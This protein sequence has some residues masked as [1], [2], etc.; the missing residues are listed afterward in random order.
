MKKNI[1]GILFIFL[2]L[3]SCVGEAS[4]TTT[5]FLTSDNIIGENEDIDMLNSIKNYVEE[6]SNG[7]IKV[8]VDSQAPS[9]GEGSRAIE[10]G[11]DVSVNLAASDAGNFLILAKYA[12]NSGKKIIFVNTGDFD[13]DSANSLRRAWDDDYSSTIFAGIN[14][15]GTYLKEAGIDYIQPLQVYPDAGPKGYLSE[16]NE[17]VNKYIAE[18]IVESVS[19]NNSHNYNNDLVITHKLAPKEMAKASQSLVESDDKQMNGT[20][21][22]YT[23]P[24]VLYLTSSYLNG[25]GLQSPANY[26]PPTDPEQYSTFAKGSYSIYDYM[27]M[28]G[29][30]K[31]FMDD[32]GRAPNYIEYDGAK[33]GY[34]DLLYNFAK[35]TQDDVD[36]S[37]MNFDREYHFDRVN[38]SI[39]ITIFPY[40]LAIIIVML[41]CIGIRKIRRR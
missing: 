8:I 26:G 5:L 15:P 7:N 36:N 29:I 40:V 10:S 20:Y 19:N 9:P 17:D 30:V 13:L 2:L 27:K 37:H 34:Y 25:N 12:V 4:A 32:N 39:L 3:S 35:I 23:A 21:N 41:A 38:E 1:L 33:I 16:Y 11:A 24:Q 22:S 6:L 18:E 31:E 28:G 14:Y